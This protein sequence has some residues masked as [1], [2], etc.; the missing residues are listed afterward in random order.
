MS[1][2]LN[3]QRR[4]LAQRLGFSALA[5]VF[6]AGLAQIGPQSPSETHP[7]L[8]KPVLPAFATLRN[9]AREIRVTL[10]DESYTLERSPEG[11]TMKGM[12]GYRIREDRLADLANGLQALN[13]GAGRT[14]DPDKFNRVGLGDPREG[15][16]GA[17]IEVIGAGGE[18]E[19]AL[20][21]GRRDD[22]VYGRLPSDKQAFRIEGDLPPLY[23]QDTWLDLD[24]L[25]IH[26]DAISAVRLFDARGQSLYLQR[27][28]GSS[29]RAFRPAPPYQD[30][31]LVSRIAVSGPAMALT[32]FAPIGVK[33]AAQ[34]K[35]KPVA[36][37]ITETHDGLEVDLRA[38]READG[39]FITLRAIEA[40]QGANRGAAINERAQGWAFELT[41]IDW[42]D[43]TPRISDIVQPPGGTPQ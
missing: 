22:F 38:Y 6:A 12:N 23:T 27:S 11:W 24:I 15:G 2:I 43:Y 18:V 35:T 40:G 17:L 5:A 26:E 9:S 3:A 13:W 16:S 10:A 1:E 34:L 20:I 32:R 30:Y 42:Q 31:K 25:D 19:A 8:G 37:H 41:E 7:R 36:R 21:T 29:E 28:V 39:Y 33:P 4:T 14:R